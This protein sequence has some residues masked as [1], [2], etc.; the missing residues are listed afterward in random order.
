M[1]VVFVHI[2]LQPGD[3][4]FGGGEVATLEPASSQGTEPEFDLVEPRTMFG[5]EMKDVVVIR[6]RQEGAAAQTPGAQASFVE[7]YGV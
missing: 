2:S 5:R 6:I 4:V 3:E 1:G 7:R